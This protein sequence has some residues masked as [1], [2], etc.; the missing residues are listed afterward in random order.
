MYPARLASLTLAAGLSVLS[1]CNSCGPGLN[2]FHRRPTTD[3]CCS[4][5]ATVGAV[6][7]FDGPALVP[8]DATIQPPPG[9]ATQPPRIVPVPQA[10]PVPYA[11]YQKTGL[12]KLFPN[13][14]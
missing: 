7:G 1:G 12:R 3:C 10:D 11:P 14:P 9:S 5:T 6:S 2:L 4:Q 13:L 8:S